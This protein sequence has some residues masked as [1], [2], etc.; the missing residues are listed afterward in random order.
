[1]LLITR[2]LYIAGG[3]LFLASLAA[4]VYAR[5]R[6]RPP[7]DSDLDDYYYEF[8]DQHPEYA[9]YNQWLRVTMAGAALGMLLVFVAIAV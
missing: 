5:I 8:E 6:L 7:D 1:M 4:H 3:F 9:R 2:M